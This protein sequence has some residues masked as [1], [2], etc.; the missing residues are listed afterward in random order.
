MEPVKRNNGAKSGNSVQVLERCFAIMEAIAANQGEASLATLGKSLSI[1]HSTI[2]RIL[3][4]LIKL[5]YVEQNQENGYYQLGLKILSLSNTILEKLD[6]RRVSKAFLEELMQR[7]GETANLVVLDGDEVVYIEKV[8]S[9]ASVRVFSLIGRRAPVHVTGA[10]KILLSEMAQPD[11]IDILQRKGM[12][13]MTSHSITSLSKFLDELALVRKQEFAMD[14]EECEL[15]A[16]CIAAPV[17]NHLGRIIASISVSAP[18]SRFS[19]E[20]VK[21]L[22]PVVKEVGLKLSKELGFSEDM[23]KLG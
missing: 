4:S 22:T 14:N 17:R 21:E 20:R 10:G 1:P 23:L 13:K 16:R 5:G 8:E 18:V 2:H 7:T 11:I 6:L 3:A 19:L 12:P 9:H 15:G